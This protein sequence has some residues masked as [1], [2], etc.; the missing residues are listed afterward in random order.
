MRRL[1]FYPTSSLHNVIFG[2]TWSGCGTKMASKGAMDW[3]EY[4]IDASKKPGMNVSRRVYVRALACLANA[5]WEQYHC[6]GLGQIDRIYM[7]GLLA[8][9]CI[10]YGFI[11]PVVMGIANEI[12]KHLSTETIAGVDYSRFDKLTHL[13]D[14]VFK[15]EKQDSLQDIMANRCAAPGCGVE[16]SEKTTLLRCAGKCPMEV[17]P[18]YCCKDCQRSV[19]SIS[20]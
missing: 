11:P 12:G 20:T 15:E 19:R 16:S 7:A 8:N 18:A 9:A 4:I 14:V 17:K 2:R 10:S 5:H 3:W 1:N 13:R 6:R